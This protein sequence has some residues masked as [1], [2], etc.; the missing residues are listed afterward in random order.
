MTHLIAATHN[1]AKLEALR[2][3]VGDAATMSPL[4]HDISPEDGEL[5]DA[6]TAAEEGRSGEEIAS[7]KAVAWS[8]V[9]PGDLVIASDGGLSIPALG[10]AWDPTRTRRIGSDGA[11]DF[12]RAESLLA[13]TAHLQGV[14]RRISWQEAVAIARNGALLGLWS[15]ES[16]PGYLTTEADSDLI[17]RSNGFWVDA[18]WICPESHDRRLVELSQAERACCGDHWSRLKSQVRDFLD[19]SITKD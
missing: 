5:R 6:L 18:L 11:T 13:R 16:E 14:E 4:P 2:C 10:D 15:A 3:L 9:L 17:A 8:R 7:A 1:E 12:E 19:E